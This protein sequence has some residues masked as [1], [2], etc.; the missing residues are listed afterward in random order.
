[1]IETETFTRWRAL[2][3]CVEVCS[4]ADVCLLSPVRLETVQVWLTYHKHLRTCSFI[5][6]L[7]IILRLYLTEEKEN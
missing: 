7:L 3:C 1:M 2:Q 6:D 4:L 5:R